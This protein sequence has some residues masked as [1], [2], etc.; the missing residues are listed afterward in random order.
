MKGRQG[1]D[2]GGRKEGKAARKDP[3]PLSPLP[4]PFLPILPAPSHFTSP[5]RRPP[6]FLSFL[7]SVLPPRAHASNTSLY[8]EGVGCSHS[9][10]STD[11]DL[12]EEGEGEGEGE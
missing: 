2:V 12:S 8:L 9:D 10:L 11:M 5:R 4:I 1:E 6:S 7:S 3:I